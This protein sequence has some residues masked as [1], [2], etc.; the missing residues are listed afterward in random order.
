MSTETLCTKNVMTDSNYQLHVSAL[1]L[2]KCL[3]C[4]TA[5]NESTCSFQLISEKR[6]FV[7]NFSQKSSSIHWKLVEFREK[8][9]QLRIVEQSIGENSLSADE[10]PQNVWIQFS[11]EN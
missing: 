4:T 8:S 3:Y 10:K 5:V 1:K 9:L 11:E 2:S 7:L 6:A